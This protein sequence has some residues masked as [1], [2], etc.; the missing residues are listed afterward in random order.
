MQFVQRPNIDCTKWDE[1]VI[2]SPQSSIYSQSFF[3]DATCQ[4]W[5][6][7]VSLDYSK[8]IV[9]PFTEKLKKKIAFTPNFI[10]YLDF[11][12]PFS[13]IEIDEFTIEVQKFFKVG[14]I[15]I[16]YDLK[17]VNTS[18]NYQVLD[19]HL[20]NNNYNNLAKRMLKRFEKSQLVFSNSSDL[21][22]ILN[23]VEN[24]LSARIKTLNKSD[25]DHF[26]KLIHQL[27]L[28]NQLFFYGIYSSTNTLVAGAFFSQFNGRITYIKG[29]SLKEYMQ[30]GSMYKLLHEGI[31]FANK[32]NFIFDFGGSNID[33]IS[34]FFTYLGGKN[35]TYSILKWGKEP[36]YYSLIKFIYH[37][38]A[39]FR[40]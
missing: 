33:T 18:A 35:K 21:T 38:L 26:G 23:L 20:E 15:A 22:S 29:V 36:M 2:N 16:N 34:Q 25:F 31:A 14:Q 17:S 32:N 5:C 4:N 6:L 37:K 30:H 1:L 27:Y 13:E 19:F 12:G 10:R 11:I 9:V 28:N 40:K 39:K 3:L 24:E 7:Y 8:G